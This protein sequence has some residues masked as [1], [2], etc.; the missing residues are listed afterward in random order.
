[1]MVLDFLIWIRLCF[2]QNL[3]IRIGFGYYWNF[4]ERIRLS[5]FN[6]RTTLAHTDVLRKNIVR[7][8]ATESGVKWNF[9]PLRISDL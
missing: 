6:I 5:N 4:S 7:A 3:R 1:M 9:W 2:E 8:L